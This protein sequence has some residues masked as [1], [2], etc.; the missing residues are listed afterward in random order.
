MLTTLMLLVFF[1]LFPAEALAASRRGLALWFDQLLPALL[2]FTVLSYVILRSNLFSFPP[3]VRRIAPEEWYIILCGFLFG[4]PIGSKLTADLYRAGRLS[5]KRATLLFICANNLSPVFVTT[6]LT[7]LLGIPPG[8]FAYAVIYGI[9]LTFLLIRLFT[10]PPFVP[11]GQKNTASGFRLDMQIVDAGIVNGFETL[12]KICGYVV[13]FSLAAELLHLL[14]MGLPICKT[15]LIGSMEVTT[16]MSELSCLGNPALRYILG[17]CFLS[18]GGVSGF[19]QTAS[20]VSG[21]DL[22]MKS[23]IS[24]RLLFAAVTLLF[25]LLFGAPGIRR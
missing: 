17:L 22:S 24:H 21:T 15:L 18:W 3:K 23:Y 19:F 11:A 8:I 4:F 12:I 2:P 5:P 25:T 1:L 6:A 16:G 7:E 9:P 13:L 10:L 14:P 20:I